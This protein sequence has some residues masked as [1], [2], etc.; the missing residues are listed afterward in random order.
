MAALMLD[1]KR[2][3]EGDCNETTKLCKSSNGTDAAT[4]GQTYSTVGTIAFAVGAVATG[5]GAYLV[6]SSK[7]GKSQVGIGPT[8]GGATVAL[9]TVIP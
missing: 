9:R 7:D 4:S 3:V 6:I 2:V 8:P 5:V 1:R